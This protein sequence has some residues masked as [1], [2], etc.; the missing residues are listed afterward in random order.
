M[1]QKQLPIV[2]HQGVYKKTATTSEAV[3][4]ITGMTIGAGI[5]G[6]PYVI[7]RSGL[8]VGLVLVVL[9]GLVMLLLNLM[10]GEIAV[11]TE[12][13][14]Q[15]PGFAG[16]YL[17][18]W[19]KNL[20]SVIIVFS[21]FGALLAYII[22]EGQTLAEIFGGPAMWW[23]IFFW[24]IGSFF[25]WRGLQ[26][27]KTL[28]RVLS[29][30]VI[31]IIVALSLFLLPKMNTANLHYVN[32]SNFFLPFGVI[33]FALHATPSIAEAH[34]L[35]PGSSKRFKKAII[36]GT[37]IP[38]AVYV[39][40]CLATVG[41]FG[42]NTA[43]I[44]T[45]GLGRAFGPAFSIIANAFAVMAMATCFMGMGVALKQTLVW[46]HKISRHVAEFTVVIVP[47]LLFLF[48]FRSFVEVL[49]LVGGLFI[50]FESLMIVLI[51]YMARRKGDLDASRYGFKHFW[52]AAVPVILFFLA[53]TV[54]SALKIF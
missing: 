52:L 25:I 30:A 4:I 31:I 45:I 11:R 42:L 38:I 24:S 54:Y 14:F 15:L 10:L 47:I 51:C 17:G 39:L 7:A 3:F 34:A 2:L 20:M 18:Q 1:Q 49:D 48:G 32:W 8:A 37:L 19:A 22:G 35:L 50:G 53:A 40:F 9:W 21:G 26:T 12:G 28:E 29:L 41:Y 44:A 43:E 36:I 23:S 27:V 33:L 13:N 6:L 46:D 16:K 5:L